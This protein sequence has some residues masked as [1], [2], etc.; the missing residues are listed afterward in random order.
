MI[1]ARATAHALMVLALLLGLSAAPGLVRGQDRGSESTRKPS[2]LPPKATTT[3][4][5][6][7]YVIATS[8]LREGRLLGCAGASCA[9]AGTSI[10][11]AQTIFIGLAVETP[12]PPPLQDYARDQVV[13][14]DG[15]VQ[16]GR[17]VGISGSAVVTDRGSLKRGDVAWI[18]LVA[19]PD[20]TAQPGAFGAPRDRPTQGERPPGRVGDPSVPDPP[21][22]PTEQPQGTRAALSCASG[23][24]WI[25]TMRGVHTP[26]N[27]HRVATE[28]EVQLCEKRRYPWNGP[29]VKGMVDLITL[30]DAGSILKWRQWIEP[31]PFGCEILSGEGVSGA[32]SPAGEISRTLEDIGRRGELRWSAPTYHLELNPA[33]LT[34]YTEVCH[35]STGTQRNTYQGGGSV[36]SGP[37][38][39]LPLEGGRM[40][41]SYGDGQPD[42]VTWSICREG[43]ACPPPQQPGP[44]AS[45]PSDPDCPEPKLEA[46]FLNLAVDQ[47]KL[48]SKQLAAKS[49]ELLKLQN[50]AR[51]YKSDFELAMY[52]CNRIGDLQT[53]LGLLMG[54]GPANVQKFTNFL[55]VVQKI[56]D[57]DPTF[58]FS[59]DKYFPER[60]HLEQAWDTLMYGA[61]KVSPGQPSSAREQLMGCAGS[62]L[63]TVFEDAMKFVQLTEQI[64]PLLPQISKI[65]NDMRAQDNKIKELWDKYH[66]ACLRYAQCKKIPANFCEGLPASR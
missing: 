60:L 34:D 30:E 15:S 58:F 17:M 5:V 51:Q 8:G 29:P 65:L 25:G 61:S 63:D 12:A 1:A 27:P 21:P 20:R 38:R 53:L 31:Q 11:I 41:G 54:Q 3:K 57:N 55:G 56:M 50:Q 40:V 48:L 33:T 16:P 4:P 2:L 62:N 23:V 7:D 6:K 45:A 35:Y 14:R 43:V 10:P 39:I 52:T 18:Y 22:P 19:R 66:A 9:I 13:L 59:N 36:H 47:L 49:D 64:E 24:R 26:G 28:V 44:V 37:G 46:D 42:F 32:Q